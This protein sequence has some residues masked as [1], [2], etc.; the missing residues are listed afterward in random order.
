MPGATIEVKWPIGE[1]RIRQEESDIWDLVMSADPHDHY[2]D[3]LE[4]NVGK[5]HWDWDWRVGQ[6]KA[7]NGRG[8]AGVD[9]LIIK[10]RNKHAAVASYL[11]LTWG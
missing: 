4:K 11:A 7:D 9:S 2:R 10:V 1:V 3:F 8:T 5:Q 6:Y